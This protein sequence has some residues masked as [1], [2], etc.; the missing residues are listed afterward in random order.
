MQEFD[1]DIGMYWCCG[2]RNPHARGCK[3]QK[4][5]TRKDK[6]QEEE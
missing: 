6:D 4:H 5:T 1:S 3:V 2:N